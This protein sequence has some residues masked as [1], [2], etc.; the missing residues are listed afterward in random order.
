MLDCL[1]LFPFI[2][3]IILLSQLYPFYLSK[4]ASAP[5]RLTVLASELDTS[6]IHSYFFFV[7][8]RLPQR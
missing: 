4:L 5:S 8:H 2:S 7:H 1:F 6:T 3:T